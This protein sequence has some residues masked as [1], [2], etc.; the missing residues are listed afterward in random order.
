RRQRRRLATE[1]LRIRRRDLGPETLERDEA[2]RDLGIFGEVN[3]ACSAATDLLHDSKVAD[4]RHEVSRMISGVALTLALRVLAAEGAALPVPPAEQK[5][6]DALAAGKPD[7]AIAGMKD[8]IAARE[9]QAA[10]DVAG[11]AAALDNLG[12]AVFQGA[13]GTEAAVAVA[14]E[15]F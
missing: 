7:E 12:A 9:A 3:Y 5:V 10:G 15:A 2:P 1:H 13:G 6:L 11:A 8:A 14:S 4:R